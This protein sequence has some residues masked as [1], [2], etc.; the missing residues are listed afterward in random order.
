MDNDE[1]KDFLHY[2][3]SE[4]DENAYLPSI[5]ESR[6]LKKRKRDIVNGESTVAYLAYCQR[7][8]KHWTMSKQ[9]ANFANNVM[10]NLRSRL[11]N[12]MTNI[13]SNFL[14]YFKSSKAAEISSFALNYASIIIHW[15]SAPR[16]IL[17]LWELIYEITCLV[18]SNDIL[19][20][21]IPRI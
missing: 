17:N 5:D 20:S 1:F 13:K 2:V 15:I 7:S 3:D 9:E 11:P 19:K 8:K 4:G 21:N 12:D 18:L 16:H 10:N 14:Y 6:A